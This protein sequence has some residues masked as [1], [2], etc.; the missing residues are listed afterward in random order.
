[1]IAPTM[2]FVANNQMHERSTFHI[3]RD[4]F[5]TQ[6]HEKLQNET[7]WTAFA[8]YL[9]SSRVHCFCLVFFDDYISVYKYLHIM[10]Y[11]PSRRRAQTNDDKVKYR[12]EQISGER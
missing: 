7:H 8:N 6:F 9:Q 2:T 10:S 1:M 11:R 4:C 5:I 12:L 3:F